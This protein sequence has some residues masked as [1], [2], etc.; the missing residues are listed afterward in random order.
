[1][2][3]ASKD[4]VAAPQLPVVEVEAFKPEISIEEFN[5]VDLRVG[6]V[7]SAEAVPEAEKL[8]RLIVHCGR[9]IQV[10][11]GVRSAYPDPTVLVG[12]R[13]LVL[14]NLKPRKMRFGMSEGMLLATSA[15][16]GAGLQLVHPDDSALGGWTVR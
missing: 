8:I 2:I 6:V 13:V 14:A 5:K 4:T 16:D 1:M 3:E 15:E 11:A 10:F 12:R 9:R 7:E